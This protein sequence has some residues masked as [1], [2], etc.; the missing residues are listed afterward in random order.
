MP[1]AYWLDLIPC[2]PFWAPRRADHAPSHCLLG[3]VA[4]RRGYAGHSSSLCSNCV[5]RPG[6]LRR[7]ATTLQP[8][9]PDPTRSKTINRSPHPRFLMVPGRLGLAELRQDQIC[10]LPVRGS[11]PILLL[12]R[13]LVHAR[14]PSGTDAIRPGP[15]VPSS[16]RRPP[17]LP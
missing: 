11:I 15:T 4:T 3:T 6:D 17:D 12:E 16:I 5:A 2:F 13:L 7:F 14:N 8:Q 10:K 1:E 9:Q